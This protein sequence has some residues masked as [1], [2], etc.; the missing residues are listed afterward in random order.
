MKLHGEGRFGFGW[1]FLWLW[2]AIVAVVVCTIQ[3]RLPGWN[4]KSLWYDDLI[5]G[6]IIRA[7]FWDMI[8]APVHVAPGLFIIWR[9][10]Y[11][12]FPDPEWSLQLLPFACAIAAI[13]V[14]ALVVRNLT[15]HDSLALLAAAV[16]A[17]NP[18]LA[19]YSVFVHQYPFEFLVTALFLLAATQLRH[20]QSID[21]HRFGR[22][23]M[24]GSAAIFFAIPSVFISFPVVHLGAAASV[25]RDWG[26]D[27]RRTVTVILT[28]AAYDIAVLTAYLLFRGR[29]HPR[30]R[31]Y[32]AHGFMPLDSVS[33]AWRFLTENGRRVLELSLPSWHLPSDPWDPVAVSWPLAI[34]GI[35]LVWLLARRQTRLFGFVAVCV[36]AALITASALHV[37]PLGARPRTDIFTFPVT[38][39]LFAAGIHAVT[40]FVPK[41]ALVRLVTVTVV[42]LFAVTRPVDVAY[43]DVNDAPLIDYLSVAVRQDDGV[44]LSEGGTFLAAFYGQWPVEIAASHQSGSGI[45][46]TILR[47]RTLSTS[48]D[49]H[50]TLFLA[51]SRPDRVWYVAFRTREKDL[52]ATI[53]NQGYRVHK[54]LETRM[55]R[56]Y[57]AVRLSRGDPSSTVGSIN[58]SLR[59]PIDRL[60]DPP[61]AWSDIDPSP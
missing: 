26:R 5:Y 48:S 60:W 8:T 9:G 31:E 32:F 54:A 41:A 35:G 44:I 42:V 39:V 45:K 10:L 4:P 59:L 14:M 12:L 56:L 49:K 55:G 3:A 7:G 6:A 43:W 37:Y 22:V 17:L 57:L 40:A 16:T 2:A 15:R 29:S 18:L 13:P 19:H 38:I 33:S 28:T 1:Q 52:L 25:A 11:E 27:R 23:A 51:K 34:I 47:D 46:A 30:I 61:V 53:E 24:A 21:S 36:Y 58:P 50:I 20:D